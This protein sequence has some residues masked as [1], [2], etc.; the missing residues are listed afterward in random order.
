MEKVEKQVV[1]RLD[2]GPGEHL[3]IIN[4]PLHHNM[5]VDPLE[6]CERDRFWS[7]IAS[8]FNG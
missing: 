7:H 3:R 1:P 2:L 5:V 6:I 8:I 4:L